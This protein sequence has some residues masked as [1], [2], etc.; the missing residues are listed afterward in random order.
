MGNENAQHGDVKLSNHLVVAEGSFGSVSWNVCDELYACLPRSKR[1]ALLGSTASEIIQPFVAGMTERLLD[2]AG[3]AGLR[4]ESL[5][6]TWSFQ[7]KRVACVFGSVDW[8]VSQGLWDSVPED[9]RDALYGI[10]ESMLHDFFAQHLY[11]RLMMFAHREM[12]G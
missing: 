8:Q 3:N 4:I 6:Q 12:R 11:R 10:A 2:Q 5:D 9:Q 7:T 1:D